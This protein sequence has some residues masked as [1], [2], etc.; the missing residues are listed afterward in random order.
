MRDVNPAISPDGRLL[1]FARTPVGPDPGEAQIWIMP[2]DGGEAWQLT[3]QRH[4]A[5]TPVWSP[6]G[7]RLLFLGQAGDDRFVVGRVRPKQAPIARRITRT[8]F[9]DDDSRAARAPDASVDDRRAARRAAPPPDPGRL[10][11]R[12]S[13]PGRRMARWIAITA[14]MGDD[15]NLMPR[16]ALYRVPSGGGAF[17]LLA[18]LPGDAWNAGHL[19][20]RPGR[21][22]SWAPMSPTRPSTP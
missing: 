15:W 7:K 17:S 4:G 16:T 8:D 20:G 3:Q 18:E 1:A 22:P 14:D 12:R 11:R 6:D 21:S 10:R 19:T 5:G 2:L 9:R 13:R